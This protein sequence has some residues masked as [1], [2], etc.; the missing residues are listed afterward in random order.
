MRRAGGARSQH[1]LNF[2][3][4]SSKAT[5]GQACTIVK[6]VQLAYVFSMAITV[7]VEARKTKRS[8]KQRSK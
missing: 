5:P 1:H 2:K 7:E 8:V 4:Y 3:A 6:Y